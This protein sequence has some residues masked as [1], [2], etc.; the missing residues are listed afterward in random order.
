MADHDT[1][2]RPDGRPPM[3]IGDAERQSMIDTL[4]EHMAAGRLDVAEYE[5][6]VEHAT[7]AI[8]DRDLDGLLDD[9][10]GGVTRDTE[11]R[12][13]QG[14]DRGR[15][16]RPRPRHPGEDWPR[17]RGRPPWAWRGGIPVPLL[18]IGAIALVVVT[19]GWILFPLLF[20]FLA[21]GRGPCGPRHRGSG[22]R[23]ADHGGQHANWW[24]DARRTG[25]PWWDRDEHEERVWDEPAHDRPRWPGRY[26]P[27]G[28]D[29]RAA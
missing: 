9:L 8:Y 29:D 15:G 27:S 19:H 13:R 10:P 2:G 12:P 25:A 28:D 18:A 6:R 20:L 5:R 11:E 4:Q 23:Y 24:T 1:P 22:R 7:G 21:T 26:D 14:G 17:S 3:R 16:G